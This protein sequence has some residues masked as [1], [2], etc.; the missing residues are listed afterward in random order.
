MRRDKSEALKFDMDFFGYAAALPLAEV[1][2]GPVVGPKLGVEFA[3][4]NGTPDDDVLDGTADAD[5]ITGRGGND[6]LSG[7]GGADTI[8]GT[9]GNDDIFGL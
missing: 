1:R 8:D 6:V 4:V 3:E 5:T 2:L 9:G 7:L